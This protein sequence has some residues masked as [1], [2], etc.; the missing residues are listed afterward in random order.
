MSNFSAID[1]DRLEPIAQALYDEA[2]PYHNFAH[3]KD[4]LRA[5]DGI[6]DRCRSEGIRIETDVV[7]YALLFHDAG[8]QEDANAKGFASKEAYAAQLA[9]DCLTSY[10]LLSS[11]ID[12]VSSAILS[13]EKDASFITTEQKAVRAADLSGMAAPFD[14][15]LRYSLLLK[16]EMEYLRSEKL[17]WSGWQANSAQIIGFYLSQEIH[18]TSYFY[19]EN[20]ESAYHKAVRNN[21]EQLLALP[22]QPSLPEAPTSA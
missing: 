14:T 8:Y 9:S 1:R 4:T 12:K 21:L 17:S 19:D 22:A 3:V 20:G 5:A 11:T 15:F 2:L 13:T 16:R 18:L 10:G 7:Y 6:L